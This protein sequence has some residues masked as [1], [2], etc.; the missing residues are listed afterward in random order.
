[1]IGHSGW[2]AATRAFSSLP[3]A[4][5]GW[6]TVRSSKSSITTRRAAP[7]IG[8]YVL[9]LLAGVGL[10]VALGTVILGNRPAP[11]IPP[12]V[13]SAS[14]PF[15]SYVAGAGIIDARTENIA[16]G[17]PA[18]GSTEAIGGKWAARD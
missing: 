12:V 17:R 18:S 9:P 13:P 10:A 15:V 5:R 16:V 3:T 4:S 2:S 11:V 7:M 8:R 14:A 6:R 1:M